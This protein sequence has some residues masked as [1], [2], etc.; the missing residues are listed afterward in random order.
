M[1]IG[2]IYIIKNY[3]NDKVYIGQ[4][5]MTVRERFMTHMKPSICKRTP[6]RKLY[7][8]IN[9]YGRENFYY[10]ILEENVPLEVLDEKEIFYINQYDSYKNGYNSTLG[11]DGRTINKL[12]NEDKVLKMAKE[13][14][15]SL[16]IAEIMQVH[17]TTIMRTLHKL[18]FYYTK[19]I[20]TNELIK[21]VEDGFTNKEIA[22]YFDVDKETIGRH[23]KKIGISRRRKNINDRQ[24]FDIEGFKKDYIE[25]VE[26]KILKEKYDLS[27]TS[28]YR[29]AKKYNLNE[30]RSEKKQKE[31]KELS[32]NIYEDYKN[33]IKINELVKKYKL[34]DKAI[35]FRIS[36]F[37]KTC[38]D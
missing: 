18:G 24:N 11:G 22:K 30:I 28:I 33:G 38:R 23:L 32:K 4:T 6:T 27:N 34:T 31:S 16:D 29:L 13:G 37:K 25:G 2:S 12:N 3:I 17:P 8:A 35:Y 36:E 26:P 21:M 9:K 19:E 20:N 10:E 1:K 5:T 14:K 7:N 15:T